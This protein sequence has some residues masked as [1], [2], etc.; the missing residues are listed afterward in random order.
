[1]SETFKLWNVACSVETPEDFTPERTTLQT[2]MFQILAFRN[3]N[4]DL[5]HV[6]R[7]G[8]QIVI[9]LPDTSDFIWSKL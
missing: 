2:K 5:P 7:L 9:M 4:I 6:L 1:M 8:T 3:G